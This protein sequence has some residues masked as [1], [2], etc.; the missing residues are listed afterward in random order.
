VILKGNDV[1]VRDLNST[2][3]SYINGEQITESP[4]QLGQVLRLGQIDV[5]LEQTPVVG[6]T[7][8]KVLD[9]TVIVGIKKDEL[10]KGTKPVSFEKNSPFQKKSNK[11]AKITIGI[12]IVLGL[13]II[14]TLIYAFVSK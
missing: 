2:N 7:G 3:G 12:A 10:D 9:K 8:K 11:A 13:V 14:V 1:I 6:P 5:R 4:L